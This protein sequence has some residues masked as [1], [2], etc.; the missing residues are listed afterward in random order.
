MRIIVMISI[1]F[2]C[3]PAMSSGAPHSCTKN[4]YLKIR[5]KIDR[6]ILGIPT[7]I[8]LRGLVGM[9][10]G[11]FSYATA[12]DDHPYMIDKLVEIEEKIPKICRT[13][14]SFTCLKKK[15]FYCTCVMSDI[16]KNIDDRDQSR[17][18][19]DK[20]LSNAMHQFI[21]E[22]AKIQRNYLNFYNS[23]STVKKDLLQSITLIVE[24]FYKKREYKAISDQPHNTLNSI[25]YQVLLLK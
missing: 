20:R 18:I 21:F 10:C 14:F 25:T 11:S 3:F 9:F 4:C 13:D 15:H 23:F 17:K 19:I 7:N 1:A 6:K 24:A 8:P 5:D 22:Q 12:V 2:H 16:I